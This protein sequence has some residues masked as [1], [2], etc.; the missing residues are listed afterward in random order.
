[1]GNLSILAISLLNL[2]LFSLQFYFLYAF[3]LVKLN[4]GGL[5]EMKERKGFFE[6]HHQRDALTCGNACLL[7]MLRDL[8]R[9]PFDL[10]RLQRELY[11]ESYGVYPGY[12]PLKV[13]A[14]F[15]RHF[16]NTRLTF[17][18]DTRTQHNLTR[19]YNEERQIELVY[20][21]LTVD[22]I[23]N[24]TQTVGPLAIRGDYFYLGYAEHTDHFITLIRE[25]K[26]RLVVLDPSYGG[27][28]S[29]DDEKLTHYLSG[30]KYIMNAS[31]L[32]IAM[33]VDLI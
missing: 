19:S 1:M 10:E 9:T 11:M 14:T 27:K 23:V 21:P 25:P 6:V 15:V 4:I 3:I 8:T 12:Y 29:L 7:M 13:A 30:Y 2:Q 16:P 22:W 17:Y 18:T 28:M 33:N 5:N 32:A 31:P 20:Q 24:H 26:H